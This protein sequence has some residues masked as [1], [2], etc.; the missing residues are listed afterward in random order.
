MLKLKNFLWLCIWAPYGL[1]TT[2]RISDIRPVWS[3]V[4]KFRYNVFLYFTL[5]SCE[6][7]SKCY[8]LDSIIAIQSIFNIKR[9]RKVSFFQ[10][11]SFKY[12]IYCVPPIGLHRPTTASCD[13]CTQIA[14]YLQEYSNGSKKD[15]LQ[16]SS[17]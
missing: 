7:S 12:S 14:H 2:N 6:V 13:S 15:I 3:F 1:Y 4:R 17:H 9:F 11:L 8:Y 16:L 10:D 5:R